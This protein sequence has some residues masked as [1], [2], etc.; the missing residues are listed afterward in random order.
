MLRS[1]LEIVST[2]QIWQHTVENFAMCHV[3]KTH[4]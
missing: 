1:S 2:V 4:K 3:L